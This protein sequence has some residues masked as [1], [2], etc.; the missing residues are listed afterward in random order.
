MRVRGRRARV[1]GFWSR[2][3][4]VEGL[5]KF[6]NRNIIALVIGAVMATCYLLFVCF[7]SWAVSSQM[8]G[9]PACCVCNKM[10]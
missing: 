9:R 7:V 10:R 4:Q 5:N 1:E 2:G 3:F 8:S 6:M